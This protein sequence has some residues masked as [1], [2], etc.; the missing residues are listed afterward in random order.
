MAYLSY[1]WLHWVFTAVL[2]FLYLQQL[3]AILVAV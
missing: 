2:S 3:G 1:F